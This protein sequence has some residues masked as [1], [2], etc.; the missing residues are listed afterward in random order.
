MLSL[1]TTFEWKI[2]SSLNTKSLPDIHAWW[3]YSVHP[4]IESLCYVLDLIVLL[5]WHGIKMTSRI[6]DLVS[7]TAWACIVKLPLITDYLAFLPT[8][9]VVCLLTDRRK[10][11][12]LLIQWG[13][14]LSK[15]NRSGHFNC[16]LFNFR[17]SSGSNDGSNGI[18]TFYIL[19]RFTRMHC[20]NDFTLQVSCHLAALLYKWTDL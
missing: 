16:L 3:Y 6:N 19:W 5:N 10:N 11:K 7:S 2:S 18:R 20:I 1:N 15:S 9:V 17:I 14:S 8:S 12:Q 4:E 13:I